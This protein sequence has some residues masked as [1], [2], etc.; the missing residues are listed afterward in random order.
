MKTKSL[1]VISRTPQGGTRFITMG[2]MGML[3]RKV[4]HL[5][6][7]KP[8]VDSLKD[9]TD[10]DFYKEYFRLKQSR[11]S[12]YLLDFENVKK[13]LSQDEGDLIYEKILEHYEFLI[14]EHDFVICNGMVNVELEELLDFDINFEIAKNLQIPTVEIINAKDMSSI[15]EIVESIDYIIHQSKRA[16]VRLLGLFV[17]RVSRE[18]L[19]E[20]RELKKEVTI[21]AIPEIKELSCPTMLDIIKELDAREVILDNSMLDRTIY[22]NKIAT[23]MLPNYLEYLEEGDLIIVSGDRCD[24][25]VGTVVANHSKNYPSIAGILLTGGIIP[26]KSIC[27]LM[28]GTDIPRIP[29]ISIRTHT[30]YALKQVERVSAQ[31][32]TYNKKKL[33]LAEG[34]FSRYI[35]LKSIKKYLSLTQPNYMSPIRFKY[36]IYAKAKESNSNI[37]LLESDDERILRAI[38]IVLRR[39]LCK[40]T[41]LGKREKIYQ[42]ASSLGLDL[43]KATIIDPHN[44]PYIDDFIDKFYE[45]RKDKGIIYP[46][47]REI[48]S[49]INYFG[50][51]MVYFGYV[52]GLVS[53]AT[54]TTKETIKPA[55]QIIKTK[56]GIDIVSSIF[57]MLVNNRVLVYGDCAINP[58]PTAEELAQI[59]ISSAQTAK[60]FGIEPIVAMLSYSSG[61]SGTGREVEKV[62][63]ATKIVK[64]L[65]PNLLIEGPIQYDTAI[66]ME[67]AKQKMPNSRVAGRATVFIFPDLNTGNNTYKAVQRSTNGVAIGP[68]LQGLNKPFNDLSRGCS[69]DDIVYT[70][71][72]T[73]IQA[74]KD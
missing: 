9:D 25:L 22:Q 50:T 3:K 55:F 24:I 16:E 2:I 14:K 6:F 49:R 17:N 23:M 35:N 60:T 12:A 74:T 29:I 20:I 36:N 4:Q 54:H 61:N 72:I 28:E 56:Q 66:D 21:F 13:L 40:I 43:S 42:K 19:D 10:M 33:A 7:C 48:M 34:I 70:I 37:L 27:K 39:G 31:I 46:M 65:A 57:F 45:L 64:E 38:D 62:R 53:G 52:D 44:N 68:I 5:A 8:V 41:L 47:A 1:M 26:P 58:N 63:E 15:D 30:R 59:A 67:V 71:A 32:T 69:V 18:L 51:M 11:D 73:A